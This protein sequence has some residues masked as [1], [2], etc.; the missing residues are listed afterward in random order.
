MS[1]GRAA[2]FF[3]LDRTLIPFNTARGWFSRERAAG[4]LSLAHTMEAAIWFGLYGLGLMDAERAFGRA[5]AVMV[6]QS[7]E[8]LERRTHCYFHEELADRFAP[9]GLAALDRHRQQGEPVVLLTSSSPYLSR[10][11]ADQLDLDTW[12]CTRFKVEEGLF[13]GELHLPLCYGDGKVTLAEGWAADA[14]VDL[15]ASWFYTDSITDLPMLERVGHPVVVQPD[16][17]LLRLARKRSW[18]VED[19]R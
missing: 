18:P 19:W 1:S 17:R 5:A 2:A 9:G 11:V 12:L 8:E 16:A 14:G 13:T 4:R 15:D 3:D 6:G 10:C 7:E